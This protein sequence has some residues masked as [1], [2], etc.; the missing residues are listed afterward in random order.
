MWGVICPSPLATSALGKTG[1]PEKGAKSSRP[2][3]YFFWRMQDKGMGSPFSPFAVPSKQML[4]KA[5]SIAVCLAAGPVRCP[6]TRTASGVICSYVNSPVC[7]EHQRG[8]LPPSST[9][10][11]LGS[12]ARKPKWFGRGLKVGAELH[13][14]VGVEGG[15]RM[16]IFEGAERLC[17]ERISYF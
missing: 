16:H 15:R 1:V 11:V 3:H 8:L 17:A 6:Q 7:S 13:T 5:T 10:R 9:S 12:N 4:F 2:T 14:H